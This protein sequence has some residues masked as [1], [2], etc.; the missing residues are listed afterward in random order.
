MGSLSTLADVKIV[1]ALLT[2]WIEMTGTNCQLD[3]HLPSRT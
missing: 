2:E 1:I 3:W